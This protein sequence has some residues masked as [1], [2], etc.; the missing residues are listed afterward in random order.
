[1]LKV[2]LE[3]CSV[4]ARISEP[5]LMLCDDHGSRRL[6]ST[7]PPFPLSPR[8]SSKLPDAI[9]HLQILLHSRAFT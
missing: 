5:K 3:M 4:G 9:N 2:R 1:M 7:S 8:D 6:K